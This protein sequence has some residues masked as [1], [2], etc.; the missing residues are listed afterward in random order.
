MAEL[1]IKIGDSNGDL[2]PK[3]GDV[4]KGFSSRAIRYMHAGH[5]C[6]ETNR[7]TV[8]G[9]VQSVPV[10]R[11]AA[12]G[13]MPN[14]SIDRQYAELVETQRY[15]R[16][17][18]TRME[19]VRLATG[20]RDEVREPL[21]EIQVNGFAKEQVF[22]FS[23]VGAVRDY[24]TTVGAT[25]LG[26][27]TTVEGKNKDVVVRDS[28]GDLVGGTIDVIG[29]HCFVQEYIRRAKHSG[30]LPLFGEPDREVWY[31]HGRWSDTITEGMKHGS[32]TVMQ[33]VWEMIEHET[34]HR[35]DG[36][37]SGCG[38]WHTRTCLSRERDPELITL[39]IDPVRRLEMIRRGQTPPFEVQYFGTD[40]QYHVAVEGSVVAAIGGGREA[41]N[42]LF[43]TTDA[44][45]DATAEELKSPLRHTEAVQIASVDEVTASV[46]NHDGVFQL[47]LSKPPVHIRRIETITVGETEYSVSPTSDSVMQVDAKSAP[48]TGAAEATGVVKRH[49]H[50]V[51]WRNQL[52]LTPKTIA[53]VADRSVRVDIRADATFDRS[54]IVEAKTVEIA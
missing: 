14:D 32:E 6:Q 15:E 26:Y 50:R 21:Y 47:T 19:R 3:D 25:A 22:G 29:K 33:S 49:K 23:R 12:T 38:V 5:I 40:R 42:F 24:L 53:D 13:L 44:F 4:V 43:V 36:E 37:C 51:D 1:A 17:S 48:S 20:E 9:T 10:R 31:G 34:S 8:N 16:T 39:A 54:T 27:R 46:G 45:D 28:V 7:V 18:R 30:K 41:R 52:G 11:D 2:R 35:E